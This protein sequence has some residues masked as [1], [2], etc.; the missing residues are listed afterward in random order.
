MSGRN[1]QGHY[2]LI[3]PHLKMRWD[4]KKSGNNST[5]P[6]PHLLLLKGLAES[7]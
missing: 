1:L 2:Y 6:I 7:F 5:T 3:M 4:T